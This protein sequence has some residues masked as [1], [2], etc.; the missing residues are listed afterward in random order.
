MVDVNVAG[1]KFNGSTTEYFE[2]LGIFVALVIVGISVALFVR[3]RIDKRRR[4]GSRLLV[5]R[6]DGRPLV[7]VPYAEC[8]LSVPDVLSTAQAHGY[9]L[10]PNPAVLRYE[11]ARGAPQTAFTGNPRAAYVAQMLDGRP[12]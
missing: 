7:Y 9:A 12:L 5:Q 10:T 11:F 1:S 4:A 8:A 6:L 2:T 3:S